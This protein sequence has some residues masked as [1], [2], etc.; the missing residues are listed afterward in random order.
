M[1][2]RALFAIEVAL[3][4]FGTIVGLFGMVQ[5]VASLFS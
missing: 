2:R 4:A 5:G 1:I 3:I